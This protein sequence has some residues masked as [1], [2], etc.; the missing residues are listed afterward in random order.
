MLEAVRMSH[1][2]NFL[3][4]ILR[5]STNGETGPSEADRL[6]VKRE[7]DNQDGTRSQ[8]VY[9]LLDTVVNHGQSL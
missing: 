1:S 8:K 3:N 6:S 5:F 7:L 2:E 4:S 9:Q